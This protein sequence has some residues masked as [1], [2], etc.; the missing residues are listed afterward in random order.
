MTKCADSVLFIGDCSYW[1]TVAN[2]L[3]LTAFVGVDS[4]FWES[5]MARQNLVNSWQGDWI[6]SFKSDLVLPSDVLGRARKGAI[7]F[8]PAPVKYRGIG[9]YY[10]CVANKDTHY[11][12]TCHHMG[13]RIDHGSIIKTVEFEILPSDDSATVRTKAA[14]Y[15]LELFNSVVS[16]IAHGRPLP[17]SDKQWANE[18]YTKS[19]LKKFI[20]E[21][22][23][24]TV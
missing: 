1:S 14:I 22:D 23:L 11:G 18:L 5:G 21:H 19:E 13:S 9:G 10:Y 7:N 12:V 2:S 24:V 8:H 20:K 15:C 6:L 4:I 3:L 17:A 16:I